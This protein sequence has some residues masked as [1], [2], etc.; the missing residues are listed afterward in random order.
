MWRTGWQQDCTLKALYPG[1]R[2][3]E[4][5]INKKGPGKGTFTMEKVQSTFTLG[6]PRRPPPAPCVVW[7][8]RPRPPSSAIIGI[9]VSY[10]TYRRDTCVCE[11]L[12]PR[13][14]LPWVI[15]VLSSIGYVRVRFALRCAI[16]G[17]SCAKLY[18]VCTC[19]A[20]PTMYG[21]G[22]VVC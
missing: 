18:R 1:K 13:C 20:S 16:L 9:P 5:I 4:I 6:S 12:A 22:S 17:Y 8:P 2:V 15:C 19:A 14:A 7:I 11:R 10:R 21:R 3:L